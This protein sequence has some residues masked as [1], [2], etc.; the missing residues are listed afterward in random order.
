[1]QIAIDYKDP[2]LLKK[3]K[4]RTT[5]GIVKKLMAF[6][7]NVTRAIE[8]IYVSNLRMKGDGICHLLNERLKR[9]KMSDERQSRT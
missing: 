2:C 3:M 6:N 8:T 7:F 1:M 4:S 5:S 9:Q